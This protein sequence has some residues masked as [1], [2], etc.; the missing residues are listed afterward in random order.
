NYNGIVDPW[1]RIKECP[2]FEVKAET[3]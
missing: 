1:E 2:C 3:W